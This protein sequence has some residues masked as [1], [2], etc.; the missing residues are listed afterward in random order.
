MK[1]REYFDIPQN[2]QIIP[3]GTFEAINREA[4]QNGGV[5]TFYF[6]HPRKF[7]DQK[8]NQ[9]RWMTIW[10]LMDYNI[11]TDT[12]VKLYPY[13]KVVKKGTMPDPDPDYL[14]GREFFTSYVLPP[15]VR[16]ML[17]AKA[18][19]YRVGAKKQ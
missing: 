16:R 1:F 9:H 13:R 15:S 17:Q 2:C 19:Y 6:S 5:V 11:D 12:V 10:Q 14:N 3:P 4:E 7:W 8:L 18:Y